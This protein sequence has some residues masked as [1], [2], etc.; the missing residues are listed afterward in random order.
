MFT[1]AQIAYGNQRFMYTRL[2]VNLHNT[3]IWSYDYW[4]VSIVIL[5]ISRFCGQKG[6]QVFKDDP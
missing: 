1:I 4:D 3:K 2:I 6:P 5:S